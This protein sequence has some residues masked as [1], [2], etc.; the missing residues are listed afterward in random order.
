L[1]KLKSGIEIQTLD[2]EHKLRLVEIGA[3]L[4]QAQLKLDSEKRKAE[5]QQM[6]DGIEMEKSMIDL[7]TKKSDFAASQMS[8]QNE[9]K[10]GEVAEQVSKSVQA[11]GKE[12]QD[13][14][15]EISETKSEAQ[16]VKQGMA[17]M[18]SMMTKKP[19]QV[20][21]MRRKKEGNKLKSVTVEYDDGDIQDV[22]VE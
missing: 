8:Q 12:L 20:K 10:I 1:D 18:G 16:T 15:K 4:E 13:L 19:R 14:K 9:S 3:D 6:H 22:A 11:I 17:A 21:V 2:E 5:A 7:E